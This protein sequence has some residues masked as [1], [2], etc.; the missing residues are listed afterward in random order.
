M[1]IKMTIQEIF[2]LILLG[3]EILFQVGIVM[4]LAFIIVN[5][6]RKKGKEDDQPN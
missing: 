4:I 1:F 6:F 5:L 2:D 3:L